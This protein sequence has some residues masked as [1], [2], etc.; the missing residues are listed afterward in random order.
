MY[1]K[2]AL[3]TTKIVIFLISLF[4]FVDKKAVFVY[5]IEASV[6]NSCAWCIV[7]IALHKNI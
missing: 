6:Y 3:L 2:I 4:S 5:V 7:I 1:L